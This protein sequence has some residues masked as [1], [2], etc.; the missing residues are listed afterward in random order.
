MQRAPTKRFGEACMALLRVLE[1]VSKCALPQQEVL[2]LKIGIQPPV[3]LLVR[4][5]HTH[6][7]FRSHDRTGTSLTVLNELGMRLNDA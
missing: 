5:R 2:F 3:L 1:P 6:Q 4:K 7:L